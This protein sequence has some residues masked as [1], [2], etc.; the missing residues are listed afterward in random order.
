MAATAARDVILVAGPTVK[1]DN[2]A[3]LL[4]PCFIS[5]LTRGMVA[6]PQAYK[7][8]PRIDATA[9]DT[10][11]SGLNI[12]LIHLPGIAI[13]MTAPAMIPITI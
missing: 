2:A 6:P 9:T 11:L 1:N 3:P 10:L 8:I 7:G 4:I 12:K 5:E 13:S